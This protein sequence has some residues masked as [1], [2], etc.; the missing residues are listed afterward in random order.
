MHT[1]LKWLQNFSVKLHSEVQAKYS[2]ALFCDVGLQKGW[3]SR[4]SAS[5]LLTASLGRVGTT[6]NHFQYPVMKNGLE[7][8]LPPACHCGI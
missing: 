5:C 3:T 7:Y 2:T 4:L 6:P 8:S 1:P